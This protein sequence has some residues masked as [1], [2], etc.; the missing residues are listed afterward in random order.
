[1]SVPAYS[2][3]FRKNIEGPVFAKKEKGYSNCTILRL[4]VAY[5]HNGYGNNR[6]KGFRFFLKPLY[7]I[8]DQILFSKIKDGFG[9]NMKFFIGGGALLDVELQRYFYAIGM[10]IC[11]G[12]GDLRKRPR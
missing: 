1:M 4:K 11:Q 2:K 9:G 6:G 12:Y 7:W 3:T 5:A 8:F 10:P